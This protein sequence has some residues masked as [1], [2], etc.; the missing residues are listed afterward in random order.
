MKTIAITSLL[1]VAGLIAAGAL[2]L[3]WLDRAFGE[4]AVVTAV[5]FVVVMAFVVVIMAGLS[6]FTLAQSRIYAG[7]IRDTADVNVANAKNFGRMLS[8]SRGGNSSSREP[9]LPMIDAEW[10]DA[11][12]QHQL[13]EPQ[14]Q[15]RLSGI[16]STIRKMLPGS[17][18][19]PMDHAMPIQR[20]ER[21]QPAGAADWGDDNQEYGD[22][23]IVS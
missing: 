17:T 8:A 18:E 20:R 9:E 10:W 15:S 23:L 7:T 22:R 2:A 21:R 19:T 1:G 5:A 3:Q 4:V 6:L 16:G 13:P 14:P 12:G 11:S